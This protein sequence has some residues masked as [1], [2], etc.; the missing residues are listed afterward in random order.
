MKS[1]LTRVKQIRLGLMIHLCESLLN[2]G[3]NFCIYMYNI[4]IYIVQN[5]NINLHLE[6]IVLA[7]VF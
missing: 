6:I 3:G 7:I 1:P 2:N 5:K 4:V